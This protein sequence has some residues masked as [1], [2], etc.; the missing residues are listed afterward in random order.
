M[1]KPKINQK[2]WSMEPSMDKPKPKQKKRIFHGQAPGLIYGVKKP[3]QKCDLPC[4]RTGSYWPKTPVEASLKVCQM[5]N[6]PTKATTNLTNPIPI[7]V[8]H[9][10]LWWSTWKAVPIFVIFSTSRF[11]RRHHSAKPFLDLNPQLPIT[12]TIVIRLEMYLLSRWI[13]TWQ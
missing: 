2:A 9:L 7:L 4:I 13:Q 6:T 3:R 12:Q 8:V 10:L 11:L 1:D 5:R